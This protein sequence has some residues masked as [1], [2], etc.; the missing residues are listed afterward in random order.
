M[1]QELYKELYELEERHWWFVGRR[2]IIFSLVK[3]YIPD[4]LNKIL[5]I[6]CGTGL[7]SELLKNKGREVV[8]LEISEEAIRYAA[9]RAPWL[10][11]IRGSFP[12][13]NLSEK[14]DL[15]TLFDVLEHIDDDNS[16][17]LAV[18][19]LLSKNG[20]AI[21]TVPAFRYLWSGH[22]ELAHHKRRYTSKELGEKIE[23]AGLEVVKI[24]YFNFFFSPLIFIV[25]FF[26]NLFGLFPKS[27]DFFM[28]P[29]RLN[30]ILA[31]IFGLE[32]LW[33]R[34]GNF[35]FGVS[36]IAIIKNK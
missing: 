32:R 18:K 23:N 11:V 3:K 4:N 8:G 2:K 13:I 36:I 20:H 16:A 9:K 19:E 22:D 35:P 25:R 33:L 21:I 14:F 10:K 15:I 7:N 30:Y 26:R 6:G 31:S 34:L 17:L 5:D 29:R 1:K 24:S 28:P 27:T 12:E